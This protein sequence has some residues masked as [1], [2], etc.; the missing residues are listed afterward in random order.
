M[1]KVSTSRAADP[2][3]DSYLSRADFS[4]SSHTS[5]L[6]VSTPLATLLGAKRYR[7]STGTGW[8]IVRI[9]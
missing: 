7:V 2:G 1:V 8:P 6:K 3:F 4:V 9:L 5:D